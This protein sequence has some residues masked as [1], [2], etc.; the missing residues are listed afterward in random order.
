MKAIINGTIID[1]F[2]QANDAALIFDDRVRGI[3]YSTEGCEL[4]DAHGGYVVPGLIDLHIHGFNG[5][6]ISDGT[7]EAVRTVSE[8]IVKNGVTSYLPTTMTMPYENITAAFN[9]VREYLKN[10]AGAGARVLGVNMEGPY[11]SPSKRGAHDIAYLKIPNADFVIENND[12]V[13]LT[14]IAPELPGAM[15]CIPALVRNGIR[16]SI[17]HTAADYETALRAIELGANQATHTFNA[18]PAINHRD[19]GAL[20]AVITDDRVYCELIADTFHVNKAFFKFLVKL[21]GDRLMLITDC[22]RAGGMGDGVYTLGGQEMHVSGIKC[23]LP[24]GTIAGSIL[25]LNKAIK[26]MYMY[27]GVSLNNVVAMATYTPACA[28]GLEHSKGAFMAGM[29]AD[30]AIFDRDFN[31]LRTIIGGETVYAADR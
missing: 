2:T 16:V 30:I 10:G 29:D 31:T 6:D 17:G 26:N 23:L 27:G 3:S 18:M 21:K 28:L 20:T 19:P 22:T 8:G 11:L 15:E 7:V 5:S 13:R 25:T 9:S 14:T 24:D 1:K 4:I 12:I